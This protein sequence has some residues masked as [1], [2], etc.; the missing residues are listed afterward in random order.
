MIRTVSGLVVLLL[1]GSVSAQSSPSY[2]LEE[3]AFNAGGAA[4]A[5]VVLSSPNFQ[6]TLASV[7]EPLVRRGLGSA[8][9]GLDAGFDSAYPPPGEVAPRCGTGAM[10]CLRFTDA[11]SLTW[12]ADPAAGV[13]NLYRDDTGDGYGS[14]EQQ[15]IADAGTMDGNEPS[16]GAAFYYLVTVRN[17]LGEEGTKGTASDTSERLGTLCP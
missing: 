4:T 6:I 7:G 1:C 3:H 17:R 5:G 13:Y 11:Q 9:F 14:C 8:S 10:P 15:S 16:P 12:P 2:T